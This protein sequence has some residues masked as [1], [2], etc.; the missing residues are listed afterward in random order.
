MKQISVVTN[1]SDRLVA[2]RQLD[3][4]RAWESLDDVRVCRCC[5]RTITGRQIEVIAPARNGE[6]RLLCPTDGCSATTSDWIY[7]SER[8]RS[9]NGWSGRPRQTRDTPFIPIPAT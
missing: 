2:L 5:G 7:P 1:L 6:P 3:R 4:T 8:M 9:R